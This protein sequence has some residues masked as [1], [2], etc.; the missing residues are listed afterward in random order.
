MFLSRLTDASLVCMIQIEMIEQVSKTYGILKDQLE[1]LYN[2]NCRGIM[3]QML[4]ACR[5]C[6]V[7]EEDCMNQ[8]MYILRHVIG[9][10]EEDYATFIDKCLSL[11]KTGGKV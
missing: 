1:I 10:E 11:E 9:F 4:N 8:V 2:S 3:L 5:R 6:H 7:D